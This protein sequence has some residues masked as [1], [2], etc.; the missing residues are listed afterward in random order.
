MEGF[1]KTSD[2]ARELGVHVN[3]IRLY[4]T[5]GFLPEIPRGEN[6]YRL[7]TPMHLEQA[8]LAH[9]TLHWP[10]VGDKTLLVD[11]VKNAANGD[12]GGAMELAY[13]YLAQVR[14]ERTYAESA[15]EFLE[16]WAA[17][18]LI[19]SSRQK[20]HIGKA[21]EYLNVSIDMLRNWE[22]NGL[23]D[24]PRDPISHYRLYGSSE[25]GRLRVIRTLVQAGY[26]LMAILR[27]LQ[28]FDSGKRDNLRAALDV[29]RTDSADEAI[30]I[31]A[32]RWLSSLIELEQRAQ[33]TIRQISK[34]IETLHHAPNPLR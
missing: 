32:D 30:E 7:Y 29:P 19:D 3:T 28:Q 24:V 31:I 12:L 4:E 20:L 23:I 34:M 21:A 17:G 11:L 8:R 1:L 15:V 10:Y 27:M 18:H 26:S 14:V 5:W 2:I 22:R 9:L 16:R 33:S 13:Q 25:F 6:G